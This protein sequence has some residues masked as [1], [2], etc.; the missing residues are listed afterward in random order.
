MFSQR[1]QCQAKVRCQDSNSSKAMMALGPSDYAKV[2]SACSC[3]SNRLAVRIS[4]SLECECNRSEAQDT[5]KLSR[6]LFTT[7]LTASPRER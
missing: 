4:G 5:F 6:R 7:Y 1:V 2:L 3:V